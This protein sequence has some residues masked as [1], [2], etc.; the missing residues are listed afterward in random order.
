M[1]YFYYLVELTQLPKTPWQTAEYLSV[2]EY[3]DPIDGPRGGYYRYFRSELDL[4][5]F[6]KLFPPGTDI[7]EEAGDRLSISGLTVQEKF[8]RSLGRVLPDDPASLAQA[9]PGKR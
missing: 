6:R 7:T 1:H 8:E 9:I 3:V 2:H 5:S 4:Q